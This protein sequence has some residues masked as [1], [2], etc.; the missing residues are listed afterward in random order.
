MQI[1]KLG[2]KEV[3]LSSFTDDIITYVENY[4]EF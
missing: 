3:K 1:I 4:K 2:K